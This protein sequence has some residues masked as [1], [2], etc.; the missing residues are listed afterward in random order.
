VALPYILNVD[1]Y[2]DSIASEIEKQTG[3]TSRLAR[4]E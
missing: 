2:R 3:R 4:F 1:R